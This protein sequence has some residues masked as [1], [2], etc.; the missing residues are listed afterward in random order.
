VA[1]LAVRSADAVDPPQSTGRDQALVPAGWRARFLGRCKESVWAPVALKALGIGLLMMSLAGIGAASIA[2]GATRGVTVPSGLP[3]VA[4]VS[5][6]WLRVTGPSGSPPAAAVEAPSASA[7]SEPAPPRASG[8]TADGK[9]ILNLATAEDL[10]RLPGIGRKRADSILAL[11][12]RLGRFKRPT[13]L[14]RVRGLGA[15]RLQRLLPHMVVD[16]PPGPVGGT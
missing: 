6:A 7:S 15:R 1:D 11:R 16:P 13:D 4:E 8:L 14:L 9:V 12:T 3:L 5:S 2:T 10:M